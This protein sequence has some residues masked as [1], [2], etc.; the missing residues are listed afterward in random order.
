[1]LASK[2]DG[3]IRVPLPHPAEFRRIDGIGRDKGGNFLQLP[4]RFYFADHSSEWKNICIPE[5]FQYS[6][7]IRREP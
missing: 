4:V 6:M 3:N 7:P 5:L 1:M 2:H